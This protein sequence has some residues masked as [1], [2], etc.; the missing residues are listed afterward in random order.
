MRSL[1]NGLVKQMFTVVQSEEKLTISADELMQRRQELHERWRREAEAD[2]ESFVSGLAAEEIEIEEGD[3]DSNVIKS[4]ESASQI[5]EN[6]QAAAETALAAAQAEAQRIRNEAIAAAESERERICEEARQQG[7]AEGMEQVQAEVE[8]IRQEYREKEAELENYYQQ[9]IETLEP[10]LVDAVTAVYEHIF[11]VELGTYRDILGNLISDALRKIEGGHDFLI[12][13]SKEDYPYV[14]MQK[15][16]IITGVVSA[17]CSVEVVEDLTLAK[18]ECLIE[19]DSG[20]YDCGLG[21]QLEEV[22]RRLMLLA[23]KKE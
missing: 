20:I 15:K 3:E 16:Q 12:H 18:N 2:T 8:V 22:K 6:A 17:N 9:Q 14:S 19:T 1:S 21:T 5:M 7:Y 13:V 10:Q 4:R 11:H 23:W